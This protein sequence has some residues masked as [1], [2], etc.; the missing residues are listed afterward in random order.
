[1]VDAVHRAI[2][3]NLGSS[4]TTHLHSVSGKMHH[5]SS[6]QSHVNAHSEFVLHL[7]KSC[8]QTG[9][10]PEETTWTDIQTDGDECS[11]IEVVWFYPDG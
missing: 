2:L 7:A 5:A 3:T 1:M 8:L 4:P 10:T 11:L 6:Y 9:S